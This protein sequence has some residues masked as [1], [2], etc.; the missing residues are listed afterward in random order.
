MLHKQSPPART[1]TKFLVSRYQA[2]P[3]NGFPE[4]LPRSFPFFFPSFPGSPRSQA[5]PG[6]AYPEALPRS[7]KQIIRLKNQ[8][9]QLATIHPDP[10]NFDN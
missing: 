2:L 6:N 9:N 10:Y 4:A 3:G 1:Q 8:L 7:F 5:E